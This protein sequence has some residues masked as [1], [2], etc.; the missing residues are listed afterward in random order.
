[1]IKAFSAATREIDDSAAAVAEIMAGLGV[2]GN[3]LKHSLGIISCF[4]EFDDTEV[5]KEICNALPFDCIGVTSIMSAAAAEIDQ[6]VFAV[7]VLTS[8]D[9]FFKTKHIPVTE[10][11]KNEIAP[12]AA[13]LLAEETEAP[14][15]ILGFFPLINT[16]GGDLILDEVSK[17]AAGVPIFGTV[18]IDHTMDYSTS[19]TI[20]NGETYREGVV[21]GALY[22]DVKFAFEMASLDEE[23]VRRQ[24][25]VITG[26]QGN[27]LTEVNGKPVLEYFEEIGLEKKTLELGLAITPLVIQPPDTVNSI[28]RAVYGLTPGG[29]AVCG[30]SMP[31]GASVAIGRMDKGDVLVTTEKVLA[32]FALSE[33]GGVV[34]CFSCMSRYLALGD[35]S[36]AETVSVLCK[37]ADD[38]PYLFTCSAGEICPLPGEDGKLIN[39]FHNFSVV[40]CWI[41]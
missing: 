30:G 2:P 29:D 37:N 32:P 33:Q 3:L 21:L 11:Y 6:I 40:L 5:L 17:A 13:A 41:G 23:K 9:C 38:K 12:A 25:A 16:V 36:E 35:N 28:A 39:Y 26:A 31:V 1:M 8:D 10:N 34:L 22:G 4:S 27:I 7:T 24:K 14:K 18:A 19:K 15:L 20:Q